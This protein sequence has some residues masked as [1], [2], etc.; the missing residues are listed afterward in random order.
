MKSLVKMLTL[1]RIDMVWC[2]RV[3][4]RQELAAQNVQNVQNA[5]YYELPIFGK[6]GSIGVGL[7]KTPRGEALKRRLDALIPQVDVKA[8]LA[9]RHRYLQPDLP[10]AGPIKL[11]FSLPTRA[12]AN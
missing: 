11:P 8:L 10:Q 2:D 9:P 3:S 4:V 7:A 1:G 6:V 5:Y 12:A